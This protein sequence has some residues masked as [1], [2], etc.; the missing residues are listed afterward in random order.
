MMTADTLYD[1]LRRVRLGGSTCLYTP[2]KCEEMTP[3][4]NETESLK[5]EKNAV[6]LAHSYVSPEI[7]EGV[8]D[9]V[10][11][12]YGLSKDA[13]KADADII[14]FVAVKFMGETAKILNPTKDVLI[15]SE[16]NGCSLADSITA[17]D[18][19]G[20]PDPAPSP[21]PTRPA[22]AVRR[23]AGPAA[24]RGGPAS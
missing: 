3:L 17:E 13:M 20:S 1:K 4:I 23:K 6:V 24:C 22:F 12:S 11:D 9:Y 15:P 14:V 19:R 2:E 7:V 16:P 5:R 10:G 21:G 18:V 8:A